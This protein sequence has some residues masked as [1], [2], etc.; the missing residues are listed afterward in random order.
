MPL[1]TTEQVSS[2]RRKR[3]GCSDPP[4]KSPCWPPTK[5]RCL[6]GLRSTAVHSHTQ[7]PQHSCPCL[8]SHL[9]RGEPHSLVAPDIESFSI[10]A[11]HCSFPQTY[12]TQI[13][14]LPHTPGLGASQPSGLDSGDFI[15][16]IVA[17]AAATDHKEGEV[18][19]HVV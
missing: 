8:L 18:R 14:L 4:M 9:S 10:L 17:V 13:Q 19:F 12:Y 5:G 7:C 11:S 6:T 16:A 15:P 1:F 2:L 3:L